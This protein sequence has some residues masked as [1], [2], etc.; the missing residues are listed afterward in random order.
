MRE[1]DLLAEA[2]APLLRLADSVGETEGWTPTLLP[3][4]VV[5]DLL[6][7]LASDAQRA[8]VALAT[9]AG[10]PAD[11]DEVGYWS[12]WRPGADDA[13]AGLRGTRTMASAWSSVRGPADLYAATARAVL[14]AAGAAE[15]D[16][17]VLTQGHALSVAS[18]LGTLVVEAGVHHLDLEPVLPDPPAPAVL[19]EVRRVLDGLLGRPAPARWS[20]VRYARLGTGRAALDADERVAVGALADRFPLFG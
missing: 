14:H 3:G 20:D 6:F 1:T 8:L 9:P 19:A 4:W 12:S 11:T 15:P 16:G 18:L 13:Q 7:H 17:I 10:R 5:R 2:Y